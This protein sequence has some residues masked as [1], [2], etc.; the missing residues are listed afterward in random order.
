MLDMPLELLQCGTGL[1]VLGHLGPVVIDI[2]GGAAVNR[3][4][5]LRGAH[6][7]TGQGHP[8]EVLGSRTHDRDSVAFGERVQPGR[9]PR[10]GT[11][12]EEAFLL[13]GHHIRAVL[14][15]SAEV[16]EHR[17]QI[18]RHRD[19]CNVCGC[20]G[21]HHLRVVVHLDAQLEAKSRD[22]PEVMPDL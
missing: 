11:P 8:V 6:Q 12:G 19:D 5:S 17:L 15:A 16:V 18:A 3:V 13:D 21:H 1:N 22:L 20:L 9:K 7:R 14:D 4:N 2:P 10:G